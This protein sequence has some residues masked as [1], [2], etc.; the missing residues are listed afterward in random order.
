MLVYAENLQSLPENIGLT[1]LQE[2]YA[3]SNQL[4]S[5]PDVLK[6]SQI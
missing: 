5:L 6:I 1:N 3:Y 4:D 2:L